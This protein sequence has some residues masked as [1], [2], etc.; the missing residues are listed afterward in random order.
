MENEQ[1]PIIEILSWA[2]F[3]FA[4]TLGAF[5]MLFDAAIKRLLDG[6]ED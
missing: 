3:I 1:N 4:A 5:V 6:P 2:G